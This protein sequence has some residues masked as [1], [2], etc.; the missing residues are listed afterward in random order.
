MWQQHQP[1]HEGELAVQRK[2]GTINQSADIGEIVQPRASFDIIR[3][4]ATKHFIVTGSVEIGTGDVWPSI[5][6]GSPGFVRISPE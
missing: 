6:C 1:F 2:V 3:F 4:F 5:I